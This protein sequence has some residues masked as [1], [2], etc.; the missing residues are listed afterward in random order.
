MTQQRHF[1][2]Y[3]SVAER[4]AGER[5]VPFWIICIQPDSRKASFPSHCNT[6]VCLYDTKLAQLCHPA[7]CETWAK[8]YKRF[9]L[10]MLGKDRGKPVLGAL[11]LPSEQRETLYCTSITCHGI[12]VVSVILCSGFASSP[13]TTLVLISSALY[14]HSRFHIKNPKSHCSHCPDNGA[15]SKE[16]LCVSNLIVI[17]VFLHNMTVGTLCHW[18]H[19]LYCHRC[20]IM[21]TYC[22]CVISIPSECLKMS[23]GDDEPLNGT[24]GPIAWSLWQWR[25]LSTITLHRP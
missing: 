5:W 8:Y 13:V 17:S 6:I 1:I 14:W 11:I 19:L 25:N 10:L 18:P 15:A 21:Q 24:F 12:I 7:S 16:T 9:Q 22:N 3:W 4:R 23:E 20:D 2:T